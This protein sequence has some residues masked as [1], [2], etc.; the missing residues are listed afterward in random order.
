[1]T[2]LLAFKGELETEI[3]GLQKAMSSHEDESSI[4]QVSRLLGQV[5]KLEYQLKTKEDECKV[6]ITEVNS[7]KSQ[8]ES[9]S[10]S[11]EKDDDLPNG[12][13]GIVQDS[14]I[15]FGL[16]VCFCAPHCLES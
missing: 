7:L 15:D 14:K 9:D 12:S 10:Q 6:L 1:M 5:T 4:S 11:T 2:E 16:Q 8:I 13:K 3:K